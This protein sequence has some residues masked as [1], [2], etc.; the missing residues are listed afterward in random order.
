MMYD[1]IVIGG[2]P[3][4]LAAAISAHEN[5]AHVLLIEREARLGGMLKQCIHDGFGLARFGERLAGP[6]YVERFIDRLEDLGIEAHTQT[7]VTRVE[8]TPAGFA[9]VTV[10]RDGVARYDTRTLVLATGCRERTAKQ[11]FIHG[12]RPAG[13][14]TAGTAQH[15][16]NLL[17][18]L[19]TRRCVILGSGDIGLIMARRLTLEGARVQAVVEILPKSGGLQRNIVQCLEDFDIPLLLRH[20]VVDIKGRERVSGVTVSAVDE[21][22]KPI[23]GTGQEYDCDT[24]LLSVGLIPENELTRELGAR[25][26]PATHGPVV[27][28]KLETTIPG[29]FACGNVLHVHGLVDSVSEEAAEAG[30]NAAVSIKQT[31]ERRLTCIICPKGCSLRVRLEA[32]RVTLV[33]GNHCKRGAQYAEKEV[34]NPT[35]TVT[36]IIPVRGG[37]EKM[38]SVKTRTDIPKAK[39]Q[40]CMRALKSV[41][42]EAPVQIG[43]VILADV[44]ETG[45]D[46]IATK[47]ISEI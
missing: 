2:G 31:E 18:E 46:I 1:V 21:Q 41:T 27:N 32:G 28:E 37:R 22:G 8:K 3:G 19:P 15:F 45:V 5:G 34:T 12:T 26:D 38:L 17:G 35:R 25:M 29:V 20:T 39:V 10:S 11:V 44:A 9:V 33:E 4:G 43:N 13:V 40:A 6:E 16:T 47:E 7:F 14:F 36:T 24:L 42:A 23:P 30:K